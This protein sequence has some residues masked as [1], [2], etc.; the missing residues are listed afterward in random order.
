MIKKSLIPICAFL[1]LTTALSAQDNDAEK[2]KGVELSVLAGYHMF[3]S[4]IDFDD[5]LSYGFRLGYHLKSGFEL[6]LSLLLAN[7]DTNFAS[8]PLERV[9][10]TSEDIVNYEIVDKG[11][12]PVDTFNVAL[13]LLYNFSSKRNPNFLPYAAIGI[14]NQNVD[15]NSISFN[16][17]D[18]FYEAGFGIR[19]FFKRYACFR[20]DARTLFG[21]FGGL[22]RGIGIIDLARPE[23]GELPA[24]ALIGN[25]SYHDYALTLGVSFFPRREAPAKAE[26]AAD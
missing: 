10:I 7:S 11:N 19:Y 2:Y 18:Y 21:E 13:D 23:L 9:I 26:A 22:A 4:E 12:T 20:F 3:D 16:E 1:F 5:A 17:D 14:G 6:E 8:I 25:R 15:M 24:E